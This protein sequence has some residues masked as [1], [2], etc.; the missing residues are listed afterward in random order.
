MAQRCAFAVRRVAVSGLFA[1]VLA[2]V[3]AVPAF[4]FTIFACE[5]RIDSRR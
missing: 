2:L 5:L 4:A 3:P 1:A